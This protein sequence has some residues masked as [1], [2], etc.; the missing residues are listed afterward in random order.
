[1]MADPVTPAEW[2]DAVDTADGLLH[3]AAARDYGLVK[4]GPEVH[5][6]RC[7]HILARGA[8]LGYTPSADS[9]ERL[10]VGLLSAVVA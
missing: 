4:G 2:Q 5:V 9:V 6:S 10:A 8:E 3:L 1:M 7:E